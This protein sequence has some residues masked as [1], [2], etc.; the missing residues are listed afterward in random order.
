[1]IECG[2]CHA[3]VKPTKKITWWV[4]GLKTILIILAVAAIAVG[5]ACGGGVDEAEEPDPIT[6]NDL[7][8]QRIECEVE[9][10]RLGGVQVTDNTVSGW[11]WEG[12]YLAETQS[13][14]VLKKLRDFHCEVRPDSTA[15]SQTPPP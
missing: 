2:S 6:K 13:W 15:A 1:M 11:Q 9:R 5:V 14:E 7:V 4:V 3:A 10:L 8:D 12:Y